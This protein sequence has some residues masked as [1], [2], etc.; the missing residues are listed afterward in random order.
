MR[1][2]TACKSQKCQ[3]GLAHLACVSPWVPTPAPWGKVPQVWAGAKGKSGFAHRGQV[4]ADHQNRIPSGHFTYT[5]L[6]V[7][8]ASH[9]RAEVQNTNPDCDLVYN[10]L[11]LHK[12]T[13]IFSR[14]VFI[15]AF[16][17]QD[18]SEILTVQ[19]QLGTT[20]QK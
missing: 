20:T 8:G 2:Q 17:L 15:G 1:S 9:T 12:P 7:R 18:H 19:Q 5:E 13:G 6:P 10:V 4:L 16:Q 14:A 11:A 3:K